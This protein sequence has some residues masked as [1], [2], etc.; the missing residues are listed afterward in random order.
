[1]HARDTAE[2]SSPKGPTDHAHQRG[3]VAHDASELRL[4]EEL[5]GEP[6]PPVPGARPSPLGDP[7][8]DQGERQV[9]EALLEAVSGAPFPATRNDLLRYVGPD[10][11]DVVASRLR[12]LPPT[13]AFQSPQEV[14][15]AFGGLGT[16]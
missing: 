10:S 15:E 2:H 6:P 3:G 8:V 16:A 1:M 14:V 9:R 4:D 13:I 7:S 5:P 11:R 12:A